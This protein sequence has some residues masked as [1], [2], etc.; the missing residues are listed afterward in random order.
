MQS[1]SVAPS[2]NYPERFRRTIV[3][4]LRITLTDLRAVADAPAAHYFTE[5]ETEQ[6]L[7]I[8]N[9]ALG[10]VE[11]WPDTCA[12][13]SILSP[14][15]ERM[16][17]RRRWIQLLTRGLSLAQQMDDLATAA[18][19]HWSLGLL[20]RQ[21]SDFAT[22]EAHWQQSQQLAVDIGQTR[23]AAKTLTEL[24]NL[25]QLQHRWAEAKYFILEAHQLLP[26]ADP[27][28]AA[29]YS[30]LGD[31]YYAERQWPAA[32]AAIEQAIALWSQAGQPTAAAGGWRGLARV[33]WATGDRMAALACYERALALYAEADDPTQRALTLMG[34]GA[35]ALETLE[36]AHAFP[37]FAEA[38]A[39]LRPLADH[40][41]LAMLDLNYG[42]A[43]RLTAA[44]GLAMQALERSLAY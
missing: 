18:H 14:H 32:V 39:I 2:T 19:L 8:L 16:G 40:F 3:Q 9:F 28:A 13:I 20:H 43:H 6:A 24:A 35:L 1:L 42:I 26:P 41:H 7:H 36:P 33:R 27:D 22:A 23:L 44:W 37:Y 12:L 10:M 11:A 15:M 25:R 30:V 4:G 21:I 29:G 38:E 5:E 31:I 17:D 34:M